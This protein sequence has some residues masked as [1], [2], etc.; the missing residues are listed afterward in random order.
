MAALRMASENKLVE[1]IMVHRVDRLGRNVYSYLT[2]KTKLRQTGVRIVSYVEHLDARPN[3][4]PSSQGTSMFVIVLADSSAKLAM[5][6]VTRPLGRNSRRRPSFWAGVVPCCWRE[7]MP[8]V[9]IVY[10]LHGAASTA[11][12]KLDTELRNQKYTKI[13][14]DTTWEG[15]YKDDVTPEGAVRTTKNE[16]AAAAQ[17]LAYPSTTSR[18]TVRPKC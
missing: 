11:Y 5:V 7:N 4:G 13:S 6:E 8:H 15:I 9:I 17:P 16:F 2:L 10:D 14:E 12:S 3:A 1:A 18:S